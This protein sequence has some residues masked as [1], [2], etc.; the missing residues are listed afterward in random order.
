MQIALCGCVP[1]SGIVL[2]GVKMIE[3]Q[4]SKHR[5]RAGK[6]KKRE[7]FTDISAGTGKA[8]LRGKVTVSRAI[9]RLYDYEETG[10]TPKQVQILIEREQ[11]LTR[12]I[13]SCRTGRNEMEKERC[14]VCGKTV[15]DGQL[16]CKDCRKRFQ[17]VT[18]GE[19]AES[20]EEIR[21][22]ADILSITAGS[23][24][25]IK[26]SME[27]LLR[28]AARLTEEREVDRE[29]HYKPKLARVQLHTAGKSE[30]YYE[31]LRADASLTAEE[32]EHAKK[33]AELFD[34]LIIT[35]SLWSYDRHRNWHL[36]SW[37]KADDERMMRAMY[38][39]EQY[40]PC[41]SYIDDF[42]G[43]KKDWLSGIY[44]SDCG[45]TFSLDEAEVLEVLQEEEDYIDPERTRR[46]VQRAK[47]DEE[48]RQRKEFMERRRKWEEK[49]A[50]WE[51][52]NSAGTNRKSYSECGSSGSRQRENKKTQQRG[53]FGRSTS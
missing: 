11:A 24:I 43:F 10:L 42:E 41:G 38:E 13:E 18:A 33:A 2:H 51:S 44:D 9:K 17:I 49:K 40:N 36:W 16:F 52:R 30:S 15:L 25:N 1:E 37:K 3:R 28:I 21:D 26:R 34:G 53:D 50:K 48:I 47:D 31:N 27:A 29:R 19:A 4:Q 14:A 8:V 35:A 12:Q 22:V 45:F 23:D 46:A 5:K 20:A 32:L 6:K 39:A 7:R